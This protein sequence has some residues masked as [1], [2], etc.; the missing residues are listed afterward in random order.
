ME[1]LKNL[2]KKSLSSNKDKNTAVDKKNEDIAELRNWYNNRNESLLIQRNILILL[3]MVAVIVIVSSVFVVDNIA[4]S[5]T[6]QPFVVEI[7]DKTGITNLVNPLARTEV[8]KD[9][10]IST[11][12]ITKYIRSR[13]SYDPLNYQRNYRTIVRLL[14]ATKVYDKF[15]GYIN[16]N[17]TNP[18]S[19]Y[20]D[21]NST[22][23]KFRSIQYLED[24]QVQARF[25]VFE[26]G[27]LKRSFPKIVT[28]KFEFDT[29]DY[30]QEER[31]VNPLGFQIT[32]YKVDDEILS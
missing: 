8:S 19:N 14:S 32:S 22:S 30:T 21:K 18:I 29:F 3:V 31:E 24:G 25:S 11:Y 27:G 1:N 26:N 6:I 2:F 12:F 20:G 28:L 9:Q 15:W 4:S 10:A 16:S 5:K 7:E 23:I 17:A 13:E